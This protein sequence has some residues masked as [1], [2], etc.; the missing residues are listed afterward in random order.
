MVSWQ[1]AARTPTNR[2]DRMTIPRNRWPIIVGG[3][4]RSGTTVLRR[5][6]N[7]HSAIHCGPEVKFFRDFYGDYPDDPVGP[8]S[9]FST[10]RSLLP[11]LELLAV[12][13]AAFVIVHERAA[14]NAGKR[15]WADKAPEN[16]LY[17]QQWQQLLGDRW[18]FVHAVRHP[19]D[20]LASIKEAT[21]PRTI[22]PDL[23][24]RIAF[25]RRYVQAGLDFG[26][27]F[28]ERYRCVVYEH[29][30]Q[31]PESELR[32][33]MEGIDEKF[34]PEQLAFNERPQQVGLED[35][36]VSGT[37]RIHALSVNRWPSVLTT[38][39]AQ[40]IWSGTRD[41]WAAATRGRDTGVSV[42]SVRTDS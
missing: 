34:E 6:L 7:A 19:L 2:N 26:A 28:P 4:H 10:A 13:G 40:R 24:G 22:P 38:D 27:A 5:T 14:A 37:H 15:R 20:T 9:F 41:V 3:C 32:G 39:E 17:L 21:F 18:I 42:P 30:A 25:Y 23:D 1:P 33:L 16:V 36:K 31:A 11:E 35:P 8:F 12:A 29:L